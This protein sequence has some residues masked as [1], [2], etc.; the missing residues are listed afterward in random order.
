MFLGLLC[1]LYLVFPL[2]FS[3]PTPNIKQWESS[4]SGTNDD[5]AVNHVLWEPVYP[6]KHLNYLEISAGPNLTMKQE[7][8][9][10]RMAFWDSLPLMENESQLVDP[11]NFLDLVYNYFVYLVKL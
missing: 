4:V 8:F 1:V 9:K 11:D 10:Q 6:G 3:H 7:W 2:C 5:R